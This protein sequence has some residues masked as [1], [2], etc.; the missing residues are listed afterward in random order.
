MSNLKKLKDEFVLVAKRILKEQ[1]STNPNTLKDYERDIIAAHDK[2]VSYVSRFYYQ[3][4]VDDQKK[5]K[6]EL[7]YIRDKT[8]A[9]FKNL[10]L[11][12]EVST[13]LLEKIVFVTPDPTA[14]VSSGS[15]NSNA[16]PSPKS[17]LKERTD[18]RDDEEK[19]EDEEK[20]DDEDKFDSFYE[21][22]DDKSE[23]TDPAP[24]S[25]TEF[26]KLAAANIK[27]YAGDP[28]KLRSF[29]NSVNVVKRVVGPHDDLLVEFVK[30]KLEGR[31]EE[32]V[33]DA[34]D[35]VDEIFDALRGE[36][37]PDNSRVIEGRMLALKV[38]KSNMQE[39]SKQAEELA[40]AL[41]RSLVVEGITQAKAKAMAIDR[42][43]DMCRQSA[44]SDLVR[45]VLAAATFN[46]PK[47]V[48]AKFVVESATET[49]EKQILAYRAFQRKNQNF[50]GRG[51]KS[52]RNGGKFQNGGNQNNNWNNNNN[53]N[54][55]QG[56]GNGRGRGKGRNNYNNNYNN[57]NSGYQERY[58]RVTENAGGPPQGW[59]ADQN[60]PQ[61]QPQRQPYY[62]QYQ[63][64]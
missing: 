47:E 55:Y 26:L 60:Q 36:I 45:S 7:I 43:V 5:V 59:R 64:N 33:P 14:N 52:G 9:C 57:N 19:S 58:V 42:T 18:S 24:M 40:E 49:K 22:F 38:D 39:Y 34:A 12:F 11:D 62:I 16:Q 61:E 56:R 31:A 63:R 35:T 46:S 50:R 15:A 20:S 32:C 13:N 23:M 41:E 25:E 1:L 54:N 51:F 37:K 29:I 21:N 3:L 27:S 53:K 48:V 28:L 6:D 4:K 17:N 2:Y 10:K 44:K 30:S 8:I